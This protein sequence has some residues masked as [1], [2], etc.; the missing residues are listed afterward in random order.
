MIIDMDD[1][2]KHILEIITDIQ[3]QM[4][5]KDD[6]KDI[7]HDV[8]NIYEQMVT[9]TDL[10]EVRRELQTQI[11]ENTRAIAELAEQIRNVLGYAKEINLLMERVSA[12]EKRIGI[13]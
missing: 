11:A 6:I 9:K 12:I 4:V 3:E 2:T 13:A 7:R 5:T 8:K 10:E 1:N